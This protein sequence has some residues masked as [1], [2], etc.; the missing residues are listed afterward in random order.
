MN[1]GERRL[2]T[3]TSFHVRQ[4]LAGEWGDVL[5]WD[6][7]SRHDYYIFLDI[8]ISE[9]RLCLTT[10]GDDKTYPRLTVYLPKKSMELPEYLTRAE[11]APLHN[12][13]GA[14][15]VEKI[16]VS[17]FCLLNPVCPKHRLYTYHKHWVKI[18]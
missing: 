4:T 14:V 18:Y 10:Q 8:L 16:M 5:S 9:P 1:E 3:V 6:K 12:G 11:R 7:N 15:G 13:W 2:I 17:H